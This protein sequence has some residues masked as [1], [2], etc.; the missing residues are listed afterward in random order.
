MLRARWTIAAA[1]TGTTSARSHLFGHLGELVL[2]QFSVAVG[3][4]LQRPLNELLRIRWTKS[5]APPR[6]ALSAGANSVTARTSSVATGA[7]RAARSAAAWTTAARSRELRLGY[8]CQLFFRHHVVFVRVG[9][10]KDSLQ[11]LRHLVLCEPVVLIRVERQIPGDGL[12]DRNRRAAFAR[13]PGSALPTR[14]TT[15]AAARSNSLA[16]R[17]TRV[18]ARPPRPKLIGAELAITVRIECFQR[19]RSTSQLASRYFA[20]AILIQSEN[21]WTHQPRTAPRPHRRLLAAR[22]RTN[23]RHADRHPPRCPFHLFCL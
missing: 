3:I 23:T 16:A 10:R 9:P 20:V 15:E 19:F 14:F 21:E 11:A 4:E 22:H 5:A 2:A 17:R 6:T 1:A 18:T 12:L 7:T 13:A 8:F